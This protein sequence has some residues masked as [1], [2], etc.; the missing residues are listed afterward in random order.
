MCF[1]SIFILD[2]LCIEYLY[3]GKLSFDIAFRTTPK[4]NRNFGLIM[5]IDE[6]G[7]FVQHN[8]SKPWKRIDMIIC[9]FKKKKTI[10]IY[11]LFS[12]LQKMGF[13]VVER[14]SIRTNQYEI[15]EYR[16]CSSQIEGLWIVLLKL[17]YC[18]FYGC[19]TVSAHIIQ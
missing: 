19:K 15:A 4:E 2:W 11:I 17:N 18:L 1:H 13:L 12:L 6:V 9:K 16:N 3:E 5:V 7:V 8:C 14:V 10:I